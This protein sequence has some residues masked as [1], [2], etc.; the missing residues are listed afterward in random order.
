VLP[1]FRRFPQ[2]FHLGPPKGG[3]AGQAE[4]TLG[5][6]VALDV[7][8]AAGDEDPERPHVGRRE[9]AHGRGVFIAGPDERAVTEDVHR[10]ARDVVVERGSVELGDQPRS[11][12]LGA[13]RR[14]GEQAVAVVLAREQPGFELD[15][16]VANH[17]ILDRRPAAQ[18]ESLSQHHR[19]VEHAPRDVGAADQRPLVL[20]CRPRHRP[21]LA[22]LADR[23][24]DR[25]PDVV[26]ED[27]VEL[28]VP[29]HLP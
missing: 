27:L 8:G 26:E 7:R 22:P 21:A 5:D 20:E 12:P 14:E 23:V 9:H 18:G 13:A 4:T 16:P 25:H 6:D 15:E 2:W 3:I 10:Q 28:H 29:R 11:T 24:L 1:Q 17:R 19:A